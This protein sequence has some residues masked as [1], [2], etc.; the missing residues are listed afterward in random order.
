MWHEGGRAGGLIY[1]E[2]A[3]AHIPLKL[4]LT[5]LASPATNVKSFL[6]GWTRAAS[7]SIRDL[8]LALDEYSSATRELRVFAS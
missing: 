4:L 5:N 7:S 1:R 8:T 3:P 6:R 2:E